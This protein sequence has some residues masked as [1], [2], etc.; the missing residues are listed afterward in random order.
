MYVNNRVLYV[1]EQHV[2]GVLPVTE[3]RNVAKNRLYN[4]F[5]AEFHDLSGKYC[6]Y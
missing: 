2:S 5:R 6:G 1:N 4:F 3:N